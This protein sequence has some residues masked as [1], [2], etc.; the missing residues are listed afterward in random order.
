MIDERLCRAFEAKEPW[1]FEEAYRR[2]T[3]LLISIAQ[4]VLLQEQDAQDSV[5]DALARIW[6]TENSYCRERGTVK[7]FLTACVRN[8]AVTRL[9]SKQRYCRV[10]ARLMEEP[11]PVDEIRFVD[12][13]EHERLQR[14]LHALPDRHRQPLE[15][16]YFEEKTHT[17]ISC[18]LNAPLGTIK[19][20]ISHGLKKLSVA[21]C[22]SGIAS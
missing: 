4:K 8:E 9:R 13:I 2:Y 22:R 18:E 16:A 21:I 10:V 19:S 12:F 15:L 14:A 20:R 11:I 1:A 7:S 6:R 5:H 3:P 17:E